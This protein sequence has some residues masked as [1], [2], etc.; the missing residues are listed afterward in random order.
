MHSTRPKPLHLLCGRAMVLLRPRRPG[1]LPHRP[2]RR[3]GRPRRR[4]GVEEGRRRRRI[5]HVLDFVEQVVQRGTGDA[6]SVALTAFPDDDSTTTPTT[7]W[8]SPA[9]RRCCARPPSPRSWPTHRRTGA[10]CHRAHRP[11]RRP[12]R[13]RP[14]G[15][16]PATTRWCASSSSADATPDELAIDEVNTS[17]YCFRRD[18]LAPALRRLDPDNA[19]GEYYL[20]DVVGGAARRRPP[21]RRGGRR[22]PRRDA[23]RQRPLPAGRSPSR[24]AAPHQR[25]AGCVRAS[26]CS[27][28]AQTYIDVTVQPGARRH[29]LP[30]HDPAGPH[31]R[32]RRRRDRARHPARRLRGRAATPWS[33][34]RPAST[35]RS[36][37]APGSGPYAVLAAGSAVPDGAVTGPFYTARSPEDGVAG[38]PG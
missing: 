32:R 8:C 27:T 7:C 6:V 28:R 10:A 35:P 4:A 20:T 38:T 12:D 30:G 31:G 17:I 3:R 23:G 2:R 33:P 36:A 25:V 15:A 14:G 24:A 13:L 21:G 9:T 37:T 11:P 19:Q 1:R 26:R 5:D 34:R 18:V 16:R 22:R 29:A